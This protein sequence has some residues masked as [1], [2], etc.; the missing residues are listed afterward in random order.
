[1]KTYH[2]LARLRLASRAEVEEALRA[3]QNLEGADLSGLD[4][5]GLNL[6]GCQLV[7]ACLS[8]ANLTG[9]VLEAANLD[10]AIGLTGRQLDHACGDAK[11]KLPSDLSVRSCP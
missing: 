4:L 3:G 6:T 2:E 7:G 10:G 8:G 5:T 9:A 11:T 1:M